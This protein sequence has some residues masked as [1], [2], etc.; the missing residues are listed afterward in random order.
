MLKHGVVALL[1]DAA[2]SRVVIL[3]PPSLLSTLSVQLPR[4]TRA[5]L[6]G[7]AVRA[8]LNLTLQ[9][10]VSFRFVSYRT[11]TELLSMEHK[12]PTTLSD[13]AIHTSRAI[14]PSHTCLVWGIAEPFVHVP[15]CSA[16][17]SIVSLCRLKASSR[18]A[19]REPHA[20]C[21]RSA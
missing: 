20:P 11:P 8:M 9:A 14:F 6:G 10:D 19:P 4:R 2:V 17:Q 7:V 1:L 16:E 3:H 15:I 21:G 18:C 12:A 13:E 5:N